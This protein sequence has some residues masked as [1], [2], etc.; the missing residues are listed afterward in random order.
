[1]GLDIIS[2]GVV[3]ATVDVEADA[4]DDNIIY[5][6]GQAP[7]EQLLLLGQR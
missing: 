5:G 6:D 3:A 1:M 7:I 2:T 4:D